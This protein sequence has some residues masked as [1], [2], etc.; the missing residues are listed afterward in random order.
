M[1]RILLCFLLVGCSQSQSRVLI[2]TQSASFAN[3]QVRY[4]MPFDL[5][6]TLAQVFGENAK[7]AASHDCT[8]LTETNRSLLGDS[9]AATGS[10]VFSEPSSNFVRWY[11]GCLIDLSG[12]L[13]ASALKDESD[14]Q[15]FWGTYLYA[16]KSSQLEPFVTLAQNDRLQIIEEKIAQLIGPTEIIADFGYFSSTAELAKKIEADVASRG[17]NAGDS[18]Q[19]ILQSIAIRDEFMSY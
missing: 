1:T 16:H 3:R 12:Q 9:S 14:A 7:K 2:E 19:L 4:M 11:M 10:P 18:M 17:M 8:T 5:M 6:Q 13:R 15:R